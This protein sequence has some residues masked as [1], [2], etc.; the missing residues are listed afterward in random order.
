MSTGSASRVVKAPVEEVFR[1]FTDVEH[2]AEHVRAIQEIRLLTPGPFKLGTRWLETRRV[3]GRIGSAEMEVTA[4]ERN[5]TYTITHRKAGVRI[6]AVFAFEPVPEGTR[7]EVAVDLSQQGLPPGLL[8][9]L[10][11]AMSNRVGGAIAEDLI[12]LKA[13]VEQE[14]S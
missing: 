10:E 11:W 8:S 14:L 12:D 7:V 5:R 13:A 2:G 9:P 1:L 4:Y 6:D 3:M